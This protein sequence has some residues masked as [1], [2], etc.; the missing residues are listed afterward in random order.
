M[1]NASWSRHHIRDVIL[2]V[3]KSCRRNETEMK[4]VDLM[5]WLL[6]DPG[7]KRT[8]KHIVIVWLSYLFDMLIIPVSHLREFPIYISYR[9]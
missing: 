3:C 2:V 9:G 4:T 6:L 7:N 5:K 1:L 8:E